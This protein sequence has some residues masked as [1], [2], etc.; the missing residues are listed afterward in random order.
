MATTTAAPPASQEL[1]VAGAPTRVRD[2][3]SSG[4]RVARWPD[5]AV[6]AAFK[7]EAAAAGLISG[8]R[9][10]TARP[11]PRL[12][13]LAE[14]GAVERERGRRRA[15]EAVEA[16][17]HAAATSPVVN[18]AVDAQLERLLRPVVVAVLDDVLLLLE[19]EP[20]RIQALIRGQRESMADELVSR[21]RT[22]AAAG[23]SAVDRL[24]FRVFHRGPHPMPAPPPAGGP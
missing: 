15:A 1:A 6:G 22:G 11:G 9:R 7:A 2:W 13:E 17:V 18:L 12:T 19:N 5:V 21:I 14:R 3:L 4:P 24:A 23:D 8:L 10:V 20:D 16:A